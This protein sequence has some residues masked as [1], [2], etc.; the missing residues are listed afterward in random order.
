M[1][2][3]VTGFFGKIPSSGDFVARNLVPGMRPAIDRFLTRN[4]ADLACTPEIWPEA[5]LRGVL[6]AA[7]GPHAMLVIPSED[8][9]GRQYPLAFATPC[10]KV[11]QVGVDCWADALLHKLSKGIGTADEVAELLTTLLPP[12]IAAE[13][14]VPPFFWSGTEE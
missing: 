2:G 11:D 5:G 1:I 3:E 14:L 12:S 13:P 7:P 8:S 4:W 10:G 6:D 9:A